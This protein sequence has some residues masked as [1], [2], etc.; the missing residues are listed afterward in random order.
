LVAEIG[1]NHVGNVKI[2]EQLT[3]LA[4][5]AGAWAVKYQAFQT[6]NFIHPESPYFEEFKSEELSFEDLAKVMDL[7]H[8]EGVKVGLTVFDSLGLKLALSAKAD[9]LKISSGDITYHQL[10]HQAVQTGLPIV[11]STGASSWAEVKKAMSICGPSLLAVL[12]CTSLYPCPLDLVNLAVL[13]RWLEGHWPAGLS[14][15]TLDLEA[16]KGA[17]GLGAVMVEKHITMDRHLPG[18]DNY[19]SATPI[20][21]MNLA[22]MNETIFEAK[23]LGHNPP[24]KGPQSSPQSPPKKAPTPPPPLFSLS[25]LAQSPLWGSRD[26]EVQRGESPQMIR[27][28]AV[29]LGDLKKGDKVTLEKIIFL[30]PPDNLLSPP[31]GPD[32]LLP[33]L[34]LKRSVNKGSVILLS[35]LD[36]PVEI[37][38]QAPLAQNPETFL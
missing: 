26:K 7:A 2:A 21:F 35:D 16:S 24:Q 10:L 4:A 11:I 17:F 37:C 22:E 1:L 5:K 28:A 13:N 3:I 38:C 8:R 25:A 15:H 33:D 27:R 20:D 14:D 32:K 6:S 23:M 31:L 30:R 9:Y 18:G 36:D 12:Q 29:A 34:R 19:V